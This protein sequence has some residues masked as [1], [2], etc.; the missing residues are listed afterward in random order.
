MSMFSVNARNARLHKFIPKH[1]KAEDAA[2]SA[3]LQFRNVTILPSAAAAVL[4]AEGEGV[5]VEKAFFDGDPPVQRFFGIDDVSVTAEFANRHVMRVDEFDE[6]RVALVD[7]IRLRFEGGPQKLVWADFSVHLE[8]PSAEEVDYFHDMINRDVSLGLEQ[9]ADL[10]DE[11]LAK[12]KGMAVKTEVNGE[13]DLKAREQRDAEQLAQAAEGLGKT[14][15][16][17]LKTKRPRKPAPAKR[18]A[19]KPAGRKGAKKRAA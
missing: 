12:A 14:A 13:L 9:S 7:K 16:I 11:M 3:E 17:P 5:E 18:A 19:K 15:E 4:L 6:I 2:R 1:G 8:D 10:I